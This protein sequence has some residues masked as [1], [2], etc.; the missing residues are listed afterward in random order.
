M[1]LSG[2]DLLPEGRSQRQPYDIAGSIIQIGDLAGRNALA[3]HSAA[4]P[5][6]AARLTP[7]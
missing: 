5:A 2:F 3:R 1:V 4:R 6:A 7:A